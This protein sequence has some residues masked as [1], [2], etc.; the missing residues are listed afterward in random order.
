[1]SPTR[2]QGNPESQPEE[3]TPL[4]GDL[5][6]PRAETP[7]PVTQ[8]LVLLLLQLCDPITS[9][10]INPYINQVRPF[11]PVEVCY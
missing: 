8:V 10:S 5:N 7:L 3:G 11:I 2:L 4:L 9:L 1:M 6:P